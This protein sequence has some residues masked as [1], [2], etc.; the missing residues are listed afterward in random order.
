M[1]MFGVDIDISIF[2]KEFEMPKSML[3][4]ELTKDL[5]DKM[6]GW[7]DEFIDIFLHQDPQIF[8]KWPHFQ[9]IE[10]DY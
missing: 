9:K 2:N 3:I 7:K 1:N 4:D 10:R 8:H 5:P 6:C